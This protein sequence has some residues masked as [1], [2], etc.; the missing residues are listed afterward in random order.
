LLL[1]RR[2][3]DGLKA[4]RQELAFAARSSFMPIGHDCLRTRKRIAQRIF[5]IKEYLA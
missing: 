5:G 3:N 1:S 2:P 4:N